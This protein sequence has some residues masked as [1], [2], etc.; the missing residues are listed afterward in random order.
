MYQGD[1][2]TDIELFEQ[3]YA[4][5]FNALQRFCYYKIPSKT[6]GDDVLQE[7]ALMPERNIGCQ[8]KMKV[9]GRASV[10]GIEGVE[11]TA[12][13]YDRDDCTMR[14]FVAQ[15]TDSHVRFLAESHMKEDVRHYYTFLDGDAFLINWGF[16][17]DNCGNN[18][19]P[20]Q[21]SII[22]R[23]GAVITCQ[24]DKEILDVVDRCIVQFNNKSYDTIR[25]MDIQC[26]NTGIITEQFVD[27]NGRTILWRRFNKNDWRFDF[28]KQKWS[29]KLPKNEKLFVNGETYVHWYDCITSYVIE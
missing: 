5:C 23:D 17:E 21:T 26:Y 25:I 8:Y 15:L 4:D 9:I 16:G 14:K 3:M 29:D 13:E 22:K 19:N 12:E 7:V 6:D 20:K 10:H 18:I 27:Q 11:I 24:T 28:Y 1:K 2:N